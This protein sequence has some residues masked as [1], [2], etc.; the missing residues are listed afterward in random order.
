MT[1]HAIVTGAS[2]GIGYAM[3]LELAR[4]SIQVLGISRRENNLRKLKQEN[5]LIETFPLDV[6]IPN[7]YSQMHIH[8]STVKNFDY[9]IIC[10]GQPGPF[11]IA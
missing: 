8:N 3:S 6:T 1:K 5:N 10:A 11:F 9:I 4:E 2:S 7:S